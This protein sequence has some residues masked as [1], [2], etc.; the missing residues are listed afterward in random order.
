[1]AI[2]K[3]GYK[4][5]TGLSQVIVTVLKDPEAQKGAP[6]NVASSELVSEGEGK[7]TLT[8]SDD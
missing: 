2:K 8:P 3:A 1:V 4:N 7:G 5:F 6:P